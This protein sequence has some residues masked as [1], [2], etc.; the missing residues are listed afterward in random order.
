MTIYH[1]KI[2]NICTWNWY[3]SGSGKMIRI[4]I[5]NTTTL[6]RINIYYYGF[7]L[8]CFMI[9]LT[10]PAN[11]PTC[12]ICLRRQILVALPP[13]HE[14]AIVMLFKRY[15]R[16]FSGLNQNRTGPRAWYE[17]QFWYFF[18]I[19]Q[20]IRIFTVSALSQYTWK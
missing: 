1:E 7:S 20:E 8:R 2:K 4:R 3:R 10:K 9:S 6:P 11:I 18:R 16:I 17:K 14:N 19:R 15:F 5:H 13:K 12:N